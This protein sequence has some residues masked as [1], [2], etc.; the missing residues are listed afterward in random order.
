MG[1]RFWSSPATTWRL[2]RFAVLALV[3]FVAV[4]GFVD[5]W[6]ATVVAVA[7]ATLSLIDDVLFRH[8]R[9]H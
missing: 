8:T 2:A 5:V 9:R 7:A 1:R 3:A 6:I 4:S